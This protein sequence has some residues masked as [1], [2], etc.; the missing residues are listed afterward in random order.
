MVGPL[1]IAAT[2]AVHRSSTI[3]CPSIL[4]LSIDVP[5]WIRIAGCHNYIKKSQVVKSTNLL[6]LNYDVIRLDLGQGY[7]S[8]RAKAHL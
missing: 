3:L 5:G 1:A 6:S 7:Q 2:F 8:S 4:A